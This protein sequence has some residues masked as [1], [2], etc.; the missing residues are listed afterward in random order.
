MLFAGMIE[1]VLES[2]LSCR[3]FSVFLCVRAFVGPS[4]YLGLI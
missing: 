3:V 2:W 1:S 4:V